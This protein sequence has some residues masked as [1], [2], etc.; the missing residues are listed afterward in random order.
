MPARFGRH[1]GFVVGAIVVFLLAAFVPSY[2]SDVADRRD[3]WVHAHAI[4]QTTWLIMLAA[5]VWAI[6]SGRT[7]FHKVVAPASALV[8]VTIVLSTMMLIRHAMMGRE[9]LDAHLKVAAFNLTSLGVFVLLYG[10]AVVHRRDSGRHASY[11]LC[12]A[13]LFVTALTQ[14][15]LEASGSLVTISVSVFG[16]FVALGQAGLL[17]ADVIVAGLSAWDWRQNRRRTVFPVAL[18]CLLAIH[19]STVTLYRLPMWRSAVQAFV[20]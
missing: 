9:I 5:Q 8:V 16:S 7:A 18:G 12:T 10:L 4:S 15:L 2:L 6:R 3:T 19:L 11:M 1:I 13:F 14:Q 20:G 17:P